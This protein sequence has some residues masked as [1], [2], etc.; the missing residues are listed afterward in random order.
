MHWKGNPML[1]GKYLVIV[2]ITILVAVAVAATIDSVK[3]SQMCKAN[4]I[5]CAHRPRP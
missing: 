4:P 2:V 1:R 3:R 5:A